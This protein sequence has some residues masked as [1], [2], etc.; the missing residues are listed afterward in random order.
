M[1][2]I[3]VFS[4]K[5]GYP[6]RAVRYFI[7]TKLTVDK[8]Y[9]IQN[10]HLSLPNQTQDI[11]H[12]RFKLRSKYPISHKRLKSEFGYSLAYL[13]K[14]FN[15]D[16]D[17]KLISNQYC[18]TLEAYSRIEE[19]KLRGADIGTQYPR[20]TRYT[21]GLQFS[22]MTKAQKNHWADSI[23]LTQEARDLIFK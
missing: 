5:Y 18:F 6:L 19:A 11:I 9:F 3:K 7:D 4:K 10:G 16:I 22:D 17:Y 1:M 23:G 2:S 8:H 13:K 15:E 14:C 21:A 20:G 12:E